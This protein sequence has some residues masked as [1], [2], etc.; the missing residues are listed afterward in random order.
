MKCSR[1]VNFASYRTLM[2]SQGV[3]ILIQLSVHKNPILR[4]LNN[5]YF[6]H[7]PIIKLGS[8]FHFLTCCTILILDPFVMLFTKST[9]ILII[10]RGVVSFWDLPY[11]KGPYGEKS[12]K[13]VRLLIQIDQKTS[14]LCKVSF[15]CQSSL[16]PLAQIILVSS[17][18][19]IL[20]FAFV[21]AER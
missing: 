20:Q 16:A 6:C 9:L 19:Q 14:A 17:C 15:L 8:N 11:H 7:I 3:L 18:T 2:L 4:P 13:N 1:K 10:F 5:R 21:F 12:K